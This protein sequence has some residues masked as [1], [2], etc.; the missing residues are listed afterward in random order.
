MFFLFL[1]Q[2]IELKQLVE[3]LCDRDGKKHP[4]SFVSAMADAS[5]NETSP[6]TQRPSKDLLVNENKIATMG[7]E[8]E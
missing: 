3:E 8:R 2:V 1:F 7:G 5:R 6:D 4:V